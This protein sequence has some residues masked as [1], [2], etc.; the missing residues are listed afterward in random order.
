M[1][2]LMLHVLTVLFLYFLLTGK[3]ATA[4]M[5]HLTSKHFSFTLTIIV[6]VTFSMTTSCQLISSLEMGGHYRLAYV[7]PYVPMVEQY[8]IC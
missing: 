6:V 8:S 1:I 4:K 3:I 7:K 5:E 2:F